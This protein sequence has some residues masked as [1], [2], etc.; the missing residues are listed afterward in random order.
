MDYLRSLP[1]KAFD[2]SIVDPPYG[3]D[4]KSVQG[5]GKLKDR[6]L[7]RHNM[8]WDIKPSK[9]YWKELFRV[10][11]NQVIC[12]GNYFQLPP[13]RCFV[14]WDKQQVWDNF[15]QC[16]FIWTSFDK[17]AKLFSFP[18]RG[19]KTD[20]GWHPTSKPMELYAYLIK[21]F[22]KPGDRILDT[23]LGSGTSRVAAYKLGY[24]FVGIERDKEYF[25]KSVEFFNMECLGISKT[26]SGH[27]VIQTSL[28]E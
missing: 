3:L 11:K 26:K 25:D 7:N 12:G 14:C 16:E 21:T 22:A 9:A 27:T 17:P 24:D 28:F 18:N 1:D 4:K 6:T 8:D 23:H 20:I 19:G 13:C 2:I 5:S 10:S 15:S